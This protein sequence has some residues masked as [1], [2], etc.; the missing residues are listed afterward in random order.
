MT[1]VFN[2]PHGTPVIIQ[3]DDAV[4]IDT[5]PE[6]EVFAATDPDSGETMMTT[7]KSEHMMDEPMGMEQEM[8]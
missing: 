3:R 6:G 7:V 2:N 4:L 5:T 8:E 1:I